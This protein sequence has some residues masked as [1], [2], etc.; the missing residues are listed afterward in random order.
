MEFCGID[1]GGYGWSLSS[2]KALPPPCEDKSSPSS[3]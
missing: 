3:I 2:Q 1:M